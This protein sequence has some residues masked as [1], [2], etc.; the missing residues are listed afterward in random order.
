MEDL[1]GERLRVLLAQKNIKQKDLQGSLQVKGKQTVSNWVNNHNMPSAQD[2]LRI[3]HFFDVT[4]DFL[5]TGKKPYVLPESK[6]IVSI[7]E[8]GEFQTWK[9]EKLEQQNESLKNNQTVPHPA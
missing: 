1:F 9:I 2:L 7:G 5:L 4:T 8:W 6:K 3:A